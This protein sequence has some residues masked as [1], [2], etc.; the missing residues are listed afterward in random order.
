[1]NRCLEINIL[2]GTMLSLHP[3]M[4]SRKGGKLAMHCHLRP[5]IASV[6]LGSN[7]EAYIWPISLTSLIRNLRESMMHCQR[8]GI[9]CY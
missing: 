8:N 9:I 1:M 7:C 2:S 3:N 4:I 6:P 5:P